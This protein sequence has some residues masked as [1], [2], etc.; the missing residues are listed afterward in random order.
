MF[1]FLLARMSGP[2]TLFD[3]LS[4][5]TY[6]LTEFA[7]VTQDSLNVGTLTMLNDVDS[8]L[9]GTKTSGPE[10]QVARLIPSPSSNLYERVLIQRRM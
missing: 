2:R 3:G 9:S 6:H 5:S 1:F 7:I 4:C 10:V 8:S